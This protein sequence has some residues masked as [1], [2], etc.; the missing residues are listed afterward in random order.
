MG[1]ASLVMALLA[2]S[3]VQAKKKAKSTKAES[4]SSSSMTTMPPPSSLVAPSSPPVDSTPP[5]PTE[6]KPTVTTA[7]EAPPSAESPA[8]AEA[9]RPRVSLMPLVLFGVEPLWEGRVF[10]QSEGTATDFRKYG[11]IGYPAIA[12]AGEIY[13]LVNVKSKFLRGFG[14]TLSFA[15]AFGFQSTGLQLSEFEDQNSGTVET[16]FMRYA[17][18]VRYRIHVNP[19]SET[20]VVLGI[21]ASMRRWQFT[22]APALGAD[23]EA[24]TADYRMGRFG[25]DGAVEVKRFSFYAS[26][27]Y[28]HAF[29]VGAPNMRELDTAHSYYLGDAPGTGGEFRGSVGVRLARWIELRLSVEYGLMAFHLKPVE[30]NGSDRVIDSYLSAGLGPYVS[31]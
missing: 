4:S 12:L 21:S 15:R 17:A 24:P 29:S 30:G 10:R 2:A 25:F 28:L 14:V 26:A 6:S 18:G 27:Y 11:A 20:P 9:D 5:P 1:T 19:D 3:S 8:D 16:S 23:V 7:P 22:F 13:P 31:F